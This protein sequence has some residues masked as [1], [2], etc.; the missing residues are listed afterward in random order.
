VG[1]FSDL[2]TATRAVI[3]PTTSSQDLM[4]IAQ[5][6]PTLWAQIASHPN[7][8]PAL[9]DWL[10]R[11]G[12]PSVSQVVARRRLATPAPVPPAGGNLF[13][14]G[15]LI[16]ALAVVLCGVSVW[17]WLGHR[18]NNSPPV[19]TSTVTVTR[20]GSATATATRGYASPP[21]T[22]P[23]CA[24]QVWPYGG[25]YPTA[26]AYGVWLDQFGTQRLLI[27]QGQSGFAIV[28]GGPWAGDNLNYFEVSKAVGGTYWV[29]FSGGSLSGVSLAL[30]PGGSV[31]VSG[32]APGYLGG[33]NGWLPLSEGYFPNGGAGSQGVPAF[34]ETAEDQVLNLQSLILQNAADKTNLTAAI[35]ACDVNAISAVLADRRAFQS[36]LQLTRVDQIPGGDQLLGILKQGISSS[37]DSDRAY[38]SWAQN[39]CPRPVPTLQSDQDAGTYKT[40]FIQ[41]WNSQIFP[42]FAGTQ[43]LDL[44]QI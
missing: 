18:G 9:L 13:P 20:S 27:C 14:W 35:P 1:D 41:M 33:T 37:I 28:R 17:L 42:N 40:Q 30:S 3:D 16:I 24:T 19:T 25:A 15:V 5:A 6:Q 31:Q 7:A 39:G 43:T 34:Q 22:M 38:L 10:D 4:S 8:Y 44:S 2:I 12:D 36:A 26:A 23:D 11:Q 29:W 21:A 32:G